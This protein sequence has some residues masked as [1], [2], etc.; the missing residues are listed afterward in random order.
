M[1]PK[2]TVDEI[3]QTAR[4]EEVIGDFVNLKKS[5][6][7]FKGLSP[8]AN[9]KTPSFMVSPSKQIFKDFSSGKGGNVVSFLM[10]HEQMSFP[11]ALK[12]LAKRYGIEVEEE[13]LDADQEEHQKHREGLFKAN[14]FALGFYETELWESDEGKAIGLSY[15]KERGFTDDTLKKFHLGYADQSFDSFFKQSVDRGYDK[16]LLLELGLVKEKE[17]KSPYDS[18]RGRVIFP[19]HNVAGRCVGFGARILSKNTKAP[20]YINSP[21]SEIYSKSNLLYGLYQSRSEIV[22]NDRCLL[23]EGYTDVISLHQSGI[24]NVVASSG[25]SLTEQQ[26][27]LIKRYSSNVTILFDGDAAGIKASF[28]GIDLLL[29]EGLNVKVLLFPEGEDPDSYSQSH[30]KEE[31]QEF[32][33]DRSEDFVFF[34]ARVLG[35][36]QDND[37]QKRSESIRDIVNSIAL[38]PDHIS[39]NIYLN[40][41]SKLLK[42]SEQVLVLE[43]NKIRRKQLNQKAKK[44]DQRAPAPFP[45]EFI[46]PF[47]PSIEPIQVKFDA[48]Y[49]EQ[50]LLRLIIA[51]HDLEIEIDGASK[52]VPAVIAEDLKVDALSF[53]D[54]QNQT[55]LNEVYK[56]LE[57]SQ[58]LSLSYFINHTNEHIRSTTVN[59]LSNPYDLH[60]WDEKE[61]YVKDEKSKLKK[62]VV[63]S[64]FSFKARKVDLMIKNLQEQ[65]SA[66]D[67]D[68]DNMRK[69]LKKKSKLDNLRIQIGEKLGRVITY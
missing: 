59:F 14:D 15:F 33:T 41:C 47:D 39:R 34:K 10:E 53:D 12:Y 67:L 16:A 1:I 40:E 24:K 35:K 42:I 20:K 63:S 8:W 48:Y 38:I 54:E 66:P 31:L 13:A 29:K 23:V 26:I 6:Q 51:Y 17:G 64:L 4:I 65:L 62:A 22:K 50:D 37:P 25:T 19:I 30:S 58:K 68:D 56:Q 11:E 28:R 44:Q 43:V 46:D 9:E 7:N 69:I 2:N 21:E 18:Y 36:D 45:E 32:I 57:V 60:K 27:R 61:I 49:Q 5:G 3:F 55:I 52:L